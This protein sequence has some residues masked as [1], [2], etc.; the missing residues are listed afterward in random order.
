[1]SVDH[2]ARDHFKV[3][4]LLPV[5]TAD[6]AAIKPDHDRFG[7]LW[8]GPQRRH[9]A[10]RRHD[11]LADPQRPGPHRARVPRPADRQ[12]FRSKAA[13]LPNGAS[14]AYRAVTYANSGATVAASRSRTATLL[15]A[16]E[17]WQAQASRRRTRTGPSPNSERTV[18]V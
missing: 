18:A 17:A 3:A 2:L 1:M 13:T 4:L 9:G 15:A 8:R 14:A 6:V 10:M 5:P 12:P 11:V 7:W 16:P